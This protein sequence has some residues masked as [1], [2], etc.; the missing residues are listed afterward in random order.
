VG[1]GSVGVWRVQYPWSEGESSFSSSSD[2]LNTVF[3]LAAYTIRATSVD[4]FTDSNTRERCPYEADG[5]I[6]A[7]GRQALQ[8][9][10]SWFRHGLEFVMSNPTWPTEWR[11]ATPIMFHDLYMLAGPAEPAARFDS[12][13]SNNTM[14]GYIYAP[15]GL[16]NYTGHPARATRDIVDWPEDDRDGFV[17]SNITSVINA[18]AA[19]SLANLASLRMANGDATGSALSR[20]ESLAIGAGMRAL[21]WDDTLGSFCDGVCSEV[22]HSATHSAVFPLWAGIQPPYSPQATP[23]SWPPSSWRLMERIAGTGVDNM[24]VYGAWAWLVAAGGAGAG[25]GAA[26]GGQTAIG[27]AAADCGGGSEPNAPDT[28]GHCW[29]HMLASNATMT[30][31]AWTRAE[32]PN[33]SWSHPWA[34]SAVELAMRRVLGVTPVAPGGALLRVSPALGT[35]RW[36][37]GAVPTMRGPVGVSVNIS[38]PTANAVTWTLRA[39]LPP[40][41][42]TTLCAPLWYPGP[43]PRS[44][45]PELPT[46]AMSLQLGTAPA[47]AVTGFVAWEDATVCVAGVLRPGASGEAASVTLSRQVPIE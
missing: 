17:F 16:V 20:S 22:S 18:Y 44:A 33:L 4:T 38:A 3:D 41:T 24:S 34:S 46:L 10:W 47:Q 39:E 45:A 26:A 28:N 1:L 27:L 40:A 43:P 31:E 32:K 23:G 19:V 21:L 11:Q 2:A 7:R 36:A 25:S 6:T 9:E 30:M 35:T 29:R 13:L 15:T 8:T 12:L 14:R 37:S 42:P 5:L